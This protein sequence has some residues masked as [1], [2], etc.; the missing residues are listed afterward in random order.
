[1]ATAIISSLYSPL[2]PT[3]ALIFTSSNTQVKGDTTSLEVM[4]VFYTRITATN[5]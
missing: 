4:L 5:Q 1:M 3:A 2:R